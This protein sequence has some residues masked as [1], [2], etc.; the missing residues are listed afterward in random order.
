MSQHTPGDGDDY[1]V[2]EPEGEFAAGDDHNEQQFMTQEQHGAGGS[3]AAAAAHGAAAAPA[4]ATLTQGQLLRCY[5]P[6]C[7]VA[8]FVWAVIKRIVPFALL[9]GTCGRIAIRRLV[10][11]LCALR[12]Y[13]TMSLHAAMQ[14]MP[15]RAWAIL[16]AYGVAPA[17][18]TKSSGA[19]HARRVAKL[20]RFVVMDLCVPLI[21]SHFYVTE[22]ESHRGRVFYYRKPV[23]SAVRSAALR[24]SMKGSYRLVRKRALLNLLR[25]RSLGVATLRLLPKPSGVVRPIA[26]LGR[27]AAFYIPIKA[28]QKKKLRGI[29]GI[30]RGEDGIVIR[31]PPRAP[32]QPPQPGTMMEVKYASVNKALRPLFSVL[33]A[34]TQAAPALLG[35]AV[36]DYGAL[37]SRLAPFIRAQRVFTTSAAPRQSGSSG[38]GARARTASPLQPGVRRPVF[39]VAADISRAFDTLPLDKLC[40]L[41]ERLLASNQYSVIRYTQVT[42]AP[43]GRLRCRWANVAVSSNSRETGQ[44]TTSLADAVCVDKPTVFSHH[45]CVFPMWRRGLCTDLVSHCTLQSSCAVLV[46]NALQQRV[47][48]SELVRQLREHLGSTLVRLGGAFFVQ[49]VGV[50]QGSILSTLLCSAL[51]ADM[52]ANHSLG[53]AG[54]S[55]AQRTSTAM[56]D[57]SGDDQT[58]LLRWVDDFL[59]MTT[60]PDVATTFLHNL[61]GGFPEYGASVSVAKTCINFDAWAPDGK[62]M[63]R[64][65][66]VTPDGRRHV[67]WC[68]LLIDSV[69]LE[70]QADNSRMMAVPLSDT[71]QTPGRDGSAPGSILATRLRGYLRPKAAALLFD[72]E[73]NGPATA[74]VNIHQCFLVAALKFHAFVSDAM[75][76]RQHGLLAAAI[77][78]ALRYGTRLVSSRLRAAPGAPKLHP[79]LQGRAIKYL[80]MVAFQ[81]ILSRRQSRYIPLLAWLKRELGSKAMRAVARRPALAAAIQPERSASLVEDR[82]MTTHK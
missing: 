57:A 25:S 7:D 4:R 74:A 72:A 60:D 44:G 13:Q 11:R 76:W 2:D 42:P 52:E 73:L 49:Q 69:T 30:T 62:R 14:R 70:V 12:R 37:Y 82:K 17:R 9:G 81:R 75:Q 80:G 15:L 50:P 48:R 55:H 34:E 20:V 31:P 8:R 22:G 78:D 38:G 41:G 61:T 68:G 5:T 66:L 58:L 24:T 77:V 40:A 1:F 51:Y 47:T 16:R 45:A 53:G 36:C 67:K 21:K 19:A 46:D 54:S 39:L 65:E 18:E 33:R 71:V 79:A 28:A 59:L 26:N 23:W 3:L 63:P 32:P 43:S 29:A 10:R 64:N 27:G 56:M 35:S 6:Q